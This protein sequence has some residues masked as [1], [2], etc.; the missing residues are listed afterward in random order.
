MALNHGNKNQPVNPVK[1]NKNKA[2]RKMAKKSRMR[3]R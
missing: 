1:K 3:N 2:K